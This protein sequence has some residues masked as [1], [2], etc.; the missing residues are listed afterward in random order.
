MTR[1]TH[2]VLIA[3][4]VLA[5]LT[6]PLSAS[7]ETGR[8]RLIGSV[9]PELK[10]ADFTSALS[11]QDQY[12]YVAA[13]GN[14][15]V[16]IE[17]GNGRE[18]R[19]VTTVDE[20]KYIGFTALDVALAGHHLLVGT[21]S[22]GLLVFDVKNVKAPRAVGKL[23]VGQ[24]VEAVATRGHL[25]LV[26][27][28]YVLTVDIANPEQPEIL[29]E[30]P[31]ETVIMD[32][33]CE[34]NLAYLAARTK[35]ATQGYLHIL[36]VGDPRA[37]RLLGQTVT[38]GIP[39]KIVLVDRYVYAAAGKTGLEIFDVGDPAAV[40][41]IGRLAITGA[42]NAVAVAATTAYLMAGQDGLF[43]ADCA[44]PTAPTLR[45]VWATDMA[46]AQG[47]TYENFVVTVGPRCQTRIWQDL[48]TAV[49]PTADG[50]YPGRVYRRKRTDSSYGTDY[51][52]FLA[53]ANL[54]EFPL[55]SPN[56]PNAFRFAETTAATLR[57]QKL[58]TLAKGWLYLATDM[59]LATNI[60]K[61]IDLP[62][63]ADFYTRRIDGRD[64]Y[65]LQ[66]DQD[67]IRADLLA[68]HADFQAEYEKLRGCRF[69]FKSKGRLAEENYD[70]DTGTLAVYPHFAFLPPGDPQIGWD[71]DE[72][73]GLP[74]PFPVVCAGEDIKAIFADAPG[75]IGQ[76]EIPTRVTT[77]LRLTG[78]SK[79]TSV[80]DT[81]TDVVVDEILIEPV[82]VG[83]LRA[84]SI[85]RE[86]G[87]WS[88]RLR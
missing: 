42:A 71:L 88:Y 68:L 35:D 48:D 44:D 54:A 40:A 25:A 22:L 62:A 58:E 81:F 64:L 20:F 18:P 78:G 17:L 8:P 15:V 52:V 82:A 86:N 24:S 1:G 27:G 55:F 85:L 76:R 34:D 84:I 51:F 5:I 2:A 6:G 61:M 7:A 31:S 41:P 83:G 33:V 46:V 50:A 32:I 60:L 77:W 37:P 73:S 12:A 79:L 59:S 28:G 65:E 39:R 74:L 49:A 29:A 69:L 21:S 14:G 26:A 38:A 53:G 63:L 10:S 75:E 43:V 11:I 45:T 80:Y 36:D 72:R 13:W 16:V 30:W 70:F 23:D 9:T 4:S 87:T 57:A 67:A 47:A 56:P 3:A 66:A 19:F